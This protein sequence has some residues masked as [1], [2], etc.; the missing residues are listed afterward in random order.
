[1]EH[2]NTIIGAIVGLL[3]GGG[4]FAA[5]SAIRKSKRDDFVT[6]LAEYKE[7]VRVLSEKVKV[8]ESKLLLSSFSSQLPFP[9][10]IKDPSG[11]MLYINNAYAKAFDVIPEEYVG[12][13][14][15]EYWGEHG[16][17]Y[18]AGDIKGMAIEGKVWIGEEPIIINGTDISDEWFVAKYGIWTGG[19]H[20][21]RI[22][23][24][25]PGLAFPHLEKVSKEGG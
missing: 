7:Q 9:F 2:I 14:D 16:K 4:I 21:P 6:I 24:A 23:V 18:R 3:S 8:L 19:D 25:N 22:C 20:G 17:R 10:W 1:M 11:K 13:T 5:I 12:K 15:E